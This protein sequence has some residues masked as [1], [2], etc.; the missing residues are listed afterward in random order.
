MGR[1]Q[2]EETTATAVA[3]QLIH[4]SR[5]NFSR[6]VRF[7]NPPPEHRSRRRNLPRLLVLRRRPFLPKDP[8]K[9]TPEL[10][11][12]ER[13][14]GILDP[15]TRQG[16]G[17]F[18]GEQYADG[19]DYASAAGAAVAFEPAENGG[20]VESAESETGVKQLSPVVVI[21]DA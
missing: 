2:A 15:S 3:P 19:V 4:A 18:G 14:L 7:G 12:V 11:L 6:A 13:E 17:E 5:I 9:P 20:G 16:G 21:A 10:R 8:A 1:D